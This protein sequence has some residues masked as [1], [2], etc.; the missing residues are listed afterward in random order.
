MLG[1]NIYLYLNTDINE[2]LD[3]FLNKVTEQNTIVRKEEY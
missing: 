3:T 1:F 2:Q